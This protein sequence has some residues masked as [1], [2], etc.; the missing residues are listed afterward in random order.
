MA[1]NSV[2]LTSAM[3]GNLIS[4]QGTVN[5]LNQTQER[6]A[7]G[8]KVNSALDNPTN[9]FAAQTLTNRAADLDSLNDG[10]NSG[11]QTLKAADAGIEGITDLIASAKGLAQAAFTSS[12][13]A[14]LATQYDAVMA[15]L[16]TL[17]SDSGYNGINLLV[18]DDLTV[19]FEGS[20]ASLTV[21]AVAS[22]QADLGILAAD[23]TDNATITAAIGELDAAL[24]TLRTTASTFASNLSIVTARQE[25]S[26][27]MINTL[28]EGADNLVLADMNEEAANM[29]MLQTRQ[30]LGTTALSISS[31][32]AQSVLRL[33]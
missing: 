13:T 28:T 33:F 9:Y 1:I 22:Q 19:N 17:V 25:F 6:L 10:M 14:S 16:D 3:R 11:I 27:N 20:S 15:Q 29:L 26:Q 2:S 32:G 18:G 21:T 24:D 12:A 31:Q 7:T 4:L 5:L 23:F 8:L 30:A